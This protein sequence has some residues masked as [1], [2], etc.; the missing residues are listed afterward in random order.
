MAGLL[1]KNQIKICFVE[2][3]ISKKLE[4]SEKKYECEPLRILWAVESS[5]QRSYHLTG[6]E[7]YNGR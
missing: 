2:N 6:A 3:R 7:S 1:G 5:R 4:C